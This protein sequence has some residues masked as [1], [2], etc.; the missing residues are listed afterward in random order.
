MTNCFSIIAVLKVLF[1][2]TTNIIYMSISQKFDI[3]ILRVFCHFFLE[4]KL[5]AVQAVTIASRLL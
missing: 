2:N 4:K 5:C 1:L 3:F